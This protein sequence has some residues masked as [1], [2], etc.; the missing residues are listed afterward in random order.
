MEVFRLEKH[1]LVTW[2]LIICLLYQNLSFCYGFNDEAP[3][4]LADPPPALPFLP[5]A[6][7]SSRKKNHL[8]LVL[9]ITL[10]ATA[11]VGIVALLLWRGNKVATVRPWATGLSGQLQKAF[12]TGVPKLKRSELEAAC[13]DFSNVI[14]STSF[15]TVYKGTLSSGV[16]IAVAS[17]AAPSAKEWSKHLES[18]FRKRIDM[19]SKVNHKN[20]VNLL[21]FCEEDEPFTRMIAFEYAPNGTLFEHL[22]IQE[23]EH[24]DW[25]MRMRIVMGMS[26]CLDYMHQLTP[27][28]AHKNLNS[29]S[30]NL[31]EDYAAKISDFG[32]CNDASTAN[33]EQTPESNVYSF[34]IILFEIIT[35]KIP[36]AGGDTVDEW[37]L[38]FLRSD[39]P[40]TE[41]VD[42]TLDSFDADQLEAIGNI[43]RS[44]VNS[45]PRRRP[46]MRDVTARLKE[47]TRIAQDGATPKISPLWWAELEILSTEA[48]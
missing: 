47:I 40:L 34:G 10:G 19:L 15:G 23:S 27:P 28:I 36:Y 48:T 21:G 11:L 7:Q 39:S 1:R 14:G 30:V 38:D 2:T 45:D 31:T 37:V 26:Y 20:F 22:H 32:L 29:S 41:L 5:S 44:C 13:E 46:K 4:A 43:I 18:S 16:E 24:L 17:V 35:G 6:G 8:A 42:P 9:S 3:P 33:T 12:V 25:M